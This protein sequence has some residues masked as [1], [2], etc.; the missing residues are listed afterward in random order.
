MR[1]LGNCGFRERWG[2]G[3]S[4]R[5][6]EFMRGDYLSTLWVVRTRGCAHFSDVWKTPSDSRRQKVDV[7]TVPYGGRMNNSRRV[8]KSSSNGDPPPG[9]C[10]R[11]VQTTSH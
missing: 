1:L 2:I 6:L 11:P 5:V 4:G 10:A 9:M 3:R 7:R 8:A